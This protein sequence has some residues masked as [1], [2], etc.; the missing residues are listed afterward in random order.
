ML[1]SLEIGRPGFDP[2]RLTERNGRQGLTDADLFARILRPG[3]RSKSFVDVSQ[4]NQAFAENDPENEVC[5]FYLN[6]APAGSALARVD[7]PISVA[8]DRRAVDAIHALVYDQCQI[9]GGYPYVLTRADE[10]AVVGRQDQEHL[11]IL[12]ENCLG[13]NGVEFGRSAKLGSKE[14]ARAGKSRHAL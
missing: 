3:Q 9:L 14:L 1:E 10:I 11:T 2:E 7:L 13:R 12:I 4:H 5:F 8:Q 6:A